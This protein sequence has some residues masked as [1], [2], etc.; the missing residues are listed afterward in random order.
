MTERQI[1]ILDSNEHY[2]F[3]IAAI[4]VDVYKEKSKP[5]IESGT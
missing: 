5:T 4:S 3:N 2:K 1:V